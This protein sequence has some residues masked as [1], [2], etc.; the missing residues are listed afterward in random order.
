MFLLYLD[1]QPPELQ[2]ALNHIAMRN[3]GKSRNHFLFVAICCSSGRVGTKDPC[4]PQHEVDDRLL[5][6]LENELDML[7]IHIARAELK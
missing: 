2:Y 5:M 7:E 3:Y 1:H 6:H 4:A